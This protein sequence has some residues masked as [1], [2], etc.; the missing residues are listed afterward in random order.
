MNIHLNNAF[1]SFQKGFHELQYGVASMFQYVVM[2]DPDTY[3]DEHISSPE[4][5]ILVNANTLLRDP[6]YVN[7]PTK[8]KETREKAKWTAIKIFAGSVLL[9][10]LS[11]A[12]PS[13]PFMFIIKSKGI[14]VGLY[15]VYKIGTYLYKNSD[16]VG[17]IFNS[18]KATHRVVVK[19]AATCAENS[20]YKDSHRVFEDTFFRPLYQ[21]MVDTNYAAAVSGVFKS[22]KKFLRAFTTGS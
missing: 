14:V 15:D 9:Y 8:F 21:G 3:R 10:G 18:L 17:S 19:E 16:S 11:V 6:E 22:G 7:Y 1:D 5:D 2:K 12:A 13:L 20:V 4:G